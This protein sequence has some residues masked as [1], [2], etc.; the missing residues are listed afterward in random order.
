MS[1]EEAKTFCDI[2]TFSHT[3]FISCT[4]S[5]NCKNCEFCS[6]PILNLVFWSCD[7][8]VITKK[9]SYPVARPHSISTQSRHLWCLLGCKHL[10]V[11]TDNSS[12]LSTGR[13]C[14]AS[15]QCSPKVAAPSRHRSAGSYRTS[16][17]PC[18]PEESREHSQFQ[19]EEVVFIQ[20]GTSLQFT[21]ENGWVPMKFQAQGSVLDPLVA[22]QWNPQFRFGSVPTH[23]LPLFG[24]RV[25]RHIRSV[26]WKQGPGKVP[27]I[28]E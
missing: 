6:E 22:F 7:C 23:P 5:K 12:P 18:A 13:C 14:L 26:V 27:S 20:L 8:K 24:F 11:K 2:D 19:S 1:S 28:P 9:E 17:G 4:A 15:L 3:I 25:L 21:S 10:V 16:T